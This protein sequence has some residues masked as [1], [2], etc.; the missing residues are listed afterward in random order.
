MNSERRQILPVSR[1]PLIAQAALRA[2]ASAETP[3][4]L[5]AAES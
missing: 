3:L 5:A 1:K 2:N 4:A